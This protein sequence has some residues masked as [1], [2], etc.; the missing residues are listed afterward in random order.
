MAPETTEPLTELEVEYADTDVAVDTE[1][2]DRVEYTELPD[3]EPVERGTLAD[4]LSLL[5]LSSPP[6]LKLVLVAKDRA[7]NFS[8]CVG[9][10]DR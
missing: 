10:G 6:N 5:S 7:C 4:L 9:D 1:R 3:T 2:L 8:E